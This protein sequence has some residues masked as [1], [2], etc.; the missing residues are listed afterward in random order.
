[1]RQDP[2]HARSWR[3]GH[4]KRARIEPRDDG[5]LS[6]VPVISNAPWLSRRLSHFPQ[7]TKFGRYGTRQY[8]FALLPKLSGARLN[9]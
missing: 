6:S 5:F 8:L 3:S 4:P 2:R 9:P 7:S 1:M